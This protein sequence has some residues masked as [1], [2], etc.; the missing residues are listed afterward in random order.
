MEGYWVWCGSPIRDEA[1]GLYH[2]FASRWPKT[3]PF[4]PFFLTDSEVVR[5][6]SKKPA[7]PYEFEE[8]VLARRGEVFWDG[9]M[10]HNPTIH[11]C[12]RT[13]TYLLFY[14]G[15]TFPGEG[16]VG[17]TYYTQPFETARANLRIGLAT[18]ASLYG[19]WKRRDEPIILPRP[20]KWD[21][22]Q[23]SNPAACVN[24]DGS[25]LL[26]Y[27][28]VAGP[29]TIFHYGMAHA[30]HFEGPY[31][32]L[33]DD[34]ILDFGPDQHIEDAYL[35]RENGRLNMIMKDMRGGI[36][37][38]EHAGLHATS[39]DGINWTVSNP[40]KAYSRKVVWDDGSVTIQGSLERPQL[41]FENGVPT[42][43]FAASADGP[44][45]FDHASNTW[46]MV[47]P[48]RHEDGE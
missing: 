17:G 3:L 1:T 44:G 26:A 13:G 24:A 45:G 38:E 48:L 9:K 32:R 12:P 4:V 21:G 16:I 39:D 36:V 23:M 34:P 19:P 33:S 29:R 7:G 27:K 15:T 40:P 6:V 42:H 8:V 46:T 18:S 25:V 2:L 35:W 14:I 10:A 37:G 11:R 22:M 30:P 20:G 31:E 43:L 5:A 28:G 47:I 41:L